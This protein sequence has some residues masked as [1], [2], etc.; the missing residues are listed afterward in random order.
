[1]GTT[2]DDFIVGLAKGK[3]GEVMDRMDRERPEL[4][5]QD[6]DVITARLGQQ[7]VAEAL[8]SRPDLAERFRDMAA[9]HFLRGIASEVRSLRSR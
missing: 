8:A 6:R 2:N 5:Q 7:E 9:E 3:I 4:S 1:M